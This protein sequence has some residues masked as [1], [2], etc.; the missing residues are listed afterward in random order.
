MKEGWVYPVIGNKF[1]A[2][3]IF[4][5]PG[6]ARCVNRELTKQLFKTKKLHFEDGSP[7][8]NLVVYN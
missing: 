3:I 4:S 8:G 6:F 1:E 2:M 7:I 5:I